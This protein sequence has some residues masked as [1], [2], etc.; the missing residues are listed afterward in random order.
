LDTVEFGFEWRQ[1]RLHLHAEDLEAA[2]SE[3]LTHWPA[4]RPRD[5][6]LPLPAAYRAAHTSLDRIALT[7][8]LCF[9]PLLPPRLDLQLVF[10]YPVSAG[11]RD[12]MRA[13]SAFPRATVEAE[14]EAEPDLRMINGLRLHGCSPRL[15]RMLGLARAELRLLAVGTGWHAGALAPQGEAALAPQGSEL[16]T[17]PALPWPALDALEFAL[18]L[19]PQAQHDEEQLA[20]CE[21]LREQL[22]GSTALLLQADAELPPATLAERLH[23]LHEHL[24][25]RPL[26]LSAATG[27]TLSAQRWEDAAHRAGLRLLA[28]GESPARALAAAW[29][30]MQRRAAVFCNREGDIAVPPRGAPEREPAWLSLGENCLPDRILQRHGLKSFSTPFSHGRSNIDYAQQMLQQR[31]A[32]LLDVAQLQDVDLGSEQVVR[33]RGYAQSAPLFEASVSQG[34]EFTHH[35]VIDDEEARQSYQRKAERLLQLRDERDVFFLYHHRA[36]AG[37]DLRQLVPRLEA[38]A[39]DFATAPRCCRILL[40]RQVIVAFPAQRRL[41]RRRL[42]PRVDD[43]AFHTTELWNGVEQPVFWAEVDDDLLALMLDPLRAWP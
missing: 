5:G 19:Q 11:M 37:T 27:E 8:L 17:A 15:L 29:A 28:A 6:Q 3:T 4:L 42:S 14:G 33:H 25:G 38:F 35:N 21:V 32:G 26:L 13:P 2:P 7:S 20:A 40:M 10:R 30:L 41:V 43:F 34:F 16:M 18:G 39:Q 31:F 36:H 12:A 24:E 23:R 1:G 9:Y 22:D